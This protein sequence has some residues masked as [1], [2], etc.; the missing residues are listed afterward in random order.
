[1]RGA[2]KRGTGGVADRVDGVHTDDRLPA[3]GKALDDENQ[4]YQQDCH[5]CCALAFT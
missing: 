1:M 5:G 3:A 4:G 2:G